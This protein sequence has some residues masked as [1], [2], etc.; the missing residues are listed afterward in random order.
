MFN[1]LRNLVSNFFCLLEK[2]E[3][4]EVGLLEDQVLIEQ[5]LE[6]CHL[7]RIQPL[8]FVLVH[9]VI[10]LLRIHVHLLDCL[11]E[12]SQPQKVLFILHVQLLLDLS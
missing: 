12:V 1:H 9:H 11:F 2:I 4:V 6:H 8:K 3:A 10:L 5:I 7:I